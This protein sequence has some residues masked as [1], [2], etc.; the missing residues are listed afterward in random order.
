MRSKLTLL[1][2]TL[3]FDTLLTDTSVLE[4]LAACSPIWCEP[5]RFENFA[6]IVINKFTIFHSAR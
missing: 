6:I 1:L 3:S 5:I 2:D 4:T